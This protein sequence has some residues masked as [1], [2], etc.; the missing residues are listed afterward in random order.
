M[1]AMNH[2]DADSVRTLLQDFGSAQVAAGRVEGFD[3]LDDADGGVAITLRRHP[4]AVPVSVRMT[5]T[6]EVYAVSFESRYT[7]VMTAY[8]DEGKFEALTSL[9]GLCQQFVARDYYELVYKRN[10][11]VVYASIHLG[12]EPAVT[13]ISSAPT[14]RLRR[15]FGFKTVRI[16]ARLGD[17]PDQSCPTRRQRPEKF[18]SSTTSAAGGGP[19]QPAAGQTT[20]EAAS[21]GR[22]LGKLRRRRWPLRSR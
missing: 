11:D 16:D 10:N 1:P 15:L 21:G 22:S 4:D 9:L 17:E 5:G 6:T 14:V 2:L 8:D 3:L 12:D 20:A 13:I 19:T 18:E 7:M